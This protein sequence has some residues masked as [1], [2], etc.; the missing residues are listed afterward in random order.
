VW[1]DGASILSGTGNTRTTTNNYANAFFLATAAGGGGT[2]FDD[3][4]LFDTSGTTCNAPMLNN[5]VI[6]TAFPNADTATKAWN[7]GA[8]IIGVDNSAAAPTSS[9]ANVVQVRLFAAAANMTLNSISVAGGSAS[10]GAINLRPVVYAGVATG[11]ALLA[12]GP[13]VVGMTAGTTT[14]MPLTTPLALTAGT[15]YAIGLMTD[16]SVGSVFASAD[17][18]NACVRG[19]ATFTSGAPA[20]LP[21]MTAGQTSYQ[22]WGNCTGSA[23]DYVSVNSNPPID[24]IA[25]IYESTVADEELFAFPALA[26]NP[27][28][29]ACVAIKA[30]LKRS[31]SGTRTV[32]VRCASGSADTAG[33]AAGVTPGTSFGWVA[34]Y[35]PTDP[36]TGSA[37]TGTGVNAAQGGVRVAS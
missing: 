25:Y 23:S 8:S 15:N 27:A 16:T 36:N 37:W 6:E 20:T 33:N 26:S 24:D 9:A 30:R 7:N 5:P 11:A 10:N 4:Y 1:L 12:A 13:T 28:S 34:N 21:T 22:M 3:L 17:V 35:Q 31:D 2:T 32:D 19:T 18:T 14:T 29:V